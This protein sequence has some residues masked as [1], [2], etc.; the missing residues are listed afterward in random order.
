MLFKCFT[1]YWDAVLD[2][3][4]DTPLCD[5]IKDK[6][7]INMRDYFYLHDNIPRLTV[8]VYYHLNSIISIQTSQNKA[9]KPQTEDIKKLLDSA[10]MPLYHHMRDWRNELAKQ[11][12]VPP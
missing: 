6:A 4:D 5:F 8:V 3:F 9:I 7:V 1:L 12:G 10:D 2:N 11:K